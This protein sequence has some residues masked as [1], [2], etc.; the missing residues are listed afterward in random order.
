MEKIAYLILVVA[1]FV[2]PSSGIAG[3][4]SNTLL[5]YVLTDMDSFVKVYEVCLL[6]YEALRDYLQSRGK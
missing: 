5:E 3:E 6:M 1:W 2:I 4:L